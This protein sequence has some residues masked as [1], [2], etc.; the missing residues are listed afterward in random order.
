MAVWGTLLNCYICLIA[1]SGEEDRNSE[2][3]ERMR[4]NCR[5]LRRPWGWGE[6]PAGSK[7]SAVHTDTAPACTGMPR[8]HTRA[9]TCAVCTHSKGHW[10]TR[11][12]AYIHMR[13]TPPN[14]PQTVPPTEDHTIKHMNQSGPFSFRLPQKSRLLSLWE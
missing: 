12:L 3:A 5:E 4:L 14:P 9:Y 8:A 13:D 6:Q 7:H 10:N 11:V 1:T 2:T